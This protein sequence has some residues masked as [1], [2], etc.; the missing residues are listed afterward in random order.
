MIEALTGQ[1]FDL[2]TLRAEPM[3][4]IIGVTAAMGPFVSV[5]LHELGHSWVA[6]RVTR[7]IILVERVLF[8]FVFEFDLATRSLGAAV[9][10]DTDIEEPYTD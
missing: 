8:P 5:T 2:A 7:P 9:G 1:G 10:G 4:W 6:L 3:P